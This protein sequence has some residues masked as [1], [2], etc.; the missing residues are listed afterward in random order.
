[1]ETLCHI[2]TVND[3][4]TNRS[5]FLCLNRHIIIIIMIS[6]FLVIL[7][8]EVDLEVVARGTPGFSGADLANLIN[9]AALHGSA[10]GREAVILEDLDFAK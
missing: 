4:N 5:N 9:Q 6:L 2:P 1:M 10:L 8:T 3:Y 7:Y